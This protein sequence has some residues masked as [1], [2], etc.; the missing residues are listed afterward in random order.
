VKKCIKEVFRFRNAVLRAQEL[1][2]Q[3]VTS[4]SLA[5]VRSRLTDLENAFTALMA[6]LSGGPSGGGETLPKAA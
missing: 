2:A 5:D 4:I 1:L 6:C 3:P